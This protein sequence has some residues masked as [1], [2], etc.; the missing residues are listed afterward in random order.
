M[1]RK[2]DFQNLY[3]TGKFSEINYDQDKKLQKHGVVYFWL[4]EHQ[5]ALILF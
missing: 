2:C 5:T 1:V 3:K 4:C